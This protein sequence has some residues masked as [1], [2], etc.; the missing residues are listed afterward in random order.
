MNPDF[1]SF[2]ETKGKPIIS[3]LTDEELCQMSNMSARLST[4]AKVRHVRTNLTTWMLNMEL[5]RRETF[6]LRTVYLIKK[7]QKARKL[8]LQVKINM[9]TTSWCSFILQFAMTHW[10]KKE[11]RLKLL[12]VHLRKVRV[13]HQCLHSLQCG[14]VLVYRLP[15]KY[16]GYHVLFSE[17]KRSWFYLVKNCGDSVWWKY[18]CIEESLNKSLLI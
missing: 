17:E 10:S 14:Y 4:L 2:Q 9:S 6:T 11:E 18:T 12:P 13:D 8:T 16:F 3:V 15:R 1:L 5:A 7:A